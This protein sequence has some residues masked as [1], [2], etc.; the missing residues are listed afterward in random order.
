MTPLTPNYIREPIRV[1]STYL[2]IPTNNSEEDSYL[3]DDRYEDT[4][5]FLYQESRPSTS[6]DTIGSS[7]VRDVDII[8]EIVKMDRSI[9]QNVLNLVEDQCTVPFIVRY[10]Q[11]AISGIDADRVRKI[12][13]VYNELKSARQRAKDVEQAL[14]KQDRLD[15]RLKAALNRCKNV[16]EVEHIYRLCRNESENAERYRNLGLG[17]SAVSVLE[18]KRLNP[19]HFLNRFAFGI[20]LICLSIC[21]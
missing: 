21:I 4:I 15:P 5:P 6:S 17:D 12:N 3:Y 18:G 20:Q 8:S 11:S 19:N 10:R 2:P 9:V 14:K 13:N 1:S 16:F 7:N